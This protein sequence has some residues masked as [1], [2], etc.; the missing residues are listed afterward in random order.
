[1]KYKNIECPDCGAPMF[2]VYN[3]KRGRKYYKYHR[4]ANPECCKTKNV[5]KEGK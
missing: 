4:C 3:S 1:M 2:A 5:N